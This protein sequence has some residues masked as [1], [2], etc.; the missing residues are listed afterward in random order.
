MWNINPRPSS[1]SIV[2]VVYSR[3]RKYKGPNRI[4]LSPSKLQA[5]ASSLNIQ[6]H[7]FA[8]EDIPIASTAIPSIVIPLSS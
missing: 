8:K 3:D 6:T 2:D 4:E 1:I 5:L 7:T